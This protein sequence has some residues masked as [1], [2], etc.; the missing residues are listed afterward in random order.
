MTQTEALKL[1]L[2]ALERI[3]LWLK[4][5]YSGIGLVGVELEA[6]TAI[7]EAL[8]EL[9]QDDEVLGFNGWGFPI[10]KPNKAMTTQTEALTLALET[11]E[12]YARD[13]GLSDLSVKAMYV[14][15]QAL[16]QPEQDKERCVGCEACID[17]ACGRDECPMGWPKAAQPEQEPDYKAI[18]QQAYESGYS[19]GY[20]DCAVKMKAQPK[21]SEQEPVAWRYKPAREDNPRWEYT[22]NH[23]LDMGDGYIRPSL[24]EYCKC[25][26]PLYAK[27]KPKLML[28]KFREMEDLLEEPAQQEPTTKEKIR[29]A[30][31]F[32]LPLYTTP[33]QRTWVG[34][35]E[36][37]IRKA[38]HHMVDGAYHYSFKQGAE[39]AEAKLKEKNA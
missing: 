37:E 38:D 13:F 4:T 7:K 35:D 16:A 29:E 8:S 1:A 3:D 12:K 20:M 30:I 17:T 18:G 33:P 6:I 9:E 31:V 10:E 36:E 26:E 5:R 28:E 27:E 39:W 34:L 14:V 22:T 19:T 21:K 24:V 23:P 2:E 11:L 15:R 32:N 25:I